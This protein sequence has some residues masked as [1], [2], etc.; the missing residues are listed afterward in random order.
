M[1]FS[2]I[3]GELTSRIGR[4]VRFGAPQDVDRRGGKAVNGTIIDE[5]W[6]DP[7]VNRQR[8]KCSGPS[9]WGDYSFCAQ[10]IKLTDG[11]ETWPTIRLAYYRRRC[12]EDWWEY[13]SQ[14]TVSSDWR[15]IQALCQK[16]L[17]KVEWFK[18]NAVIPSN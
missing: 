7:E 17:S 10:L 9:C 13:A 14:T 1:G 11:N 2:K 16:T 12:G 3:K 5:I 18:D 15:T 6:A 8:H 4:S